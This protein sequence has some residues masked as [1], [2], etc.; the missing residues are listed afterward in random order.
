MT[1]S[2]Q[3]GT[4]E[5]HRRVNDGILV[6]HLWTVQDD[7]LWVAVADSKTGETFGVEVRDRTR[8]LEVFRHPYAYAAC[9]ALDTRTATADAKSSMRVRA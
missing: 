1:D 3:T 8:A 5:L 2:N 7:R 9:D 4:R 6:R